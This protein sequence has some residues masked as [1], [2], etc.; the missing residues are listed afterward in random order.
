VQAGNAVRMMVSPAKSAA[1][2][3]QGEFRANLPDQ[4]RA[5]GRPVFSGADKGTD[6]VQ[7]PF[8][9]HSRMGGRLGRL[10]NSG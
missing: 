10:E 6:Q 2:N 1:G 9:V 5:T 4:K 3:L 8:D 7:S